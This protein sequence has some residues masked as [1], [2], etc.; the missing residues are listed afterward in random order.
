MIVTPPAQDHPTIYP[1]QTFHFSYP[2]PTTSI[3]EEMYS[4]HGGLYGMDDYRLL[5]KESVDSPDKSWAR[6]FREFLTFEQ[7]FMKVREGTP[8]EG[9]AWFLVALIY[10]PD[11]PIS[12][13]ASALRAR[14]VKKVTAW[15]V[16]L[17]MFPEAVI[18]FLA[19]SRLGAIH[20]L[21][22]D[23]TAPAVIA[24]RLLGCSSQVI[25]A[26]DYTKRG[27]REL[28]MKRLL[29]EALRSCPA[30]HTVL[31]RDVRWDD[32]V[33]PAAELVQ[34]E[35]MDSEDPLFIMYPSGSTGKPK[36]LVRS[37]AGFLTG[38]AVT[39]K[40]VIDIRP[41]DIFC[42]GD[43]AWISGQLVNALYVPLLLGPSRYWDICEKY[44]VTQFYVAPTTVR[45]LKWLRDS[46][47]PHT[48]CHRCWYY[49]AMGKGRAHLLDT[50]FQTETGSLVL[51]PLAGVTPTK[52]GSCTLPFFGV[53]T[54][55]CPE[56]IL[57]IR[58]PWPGMARSAWGD[59]QRFVN[60]YFQAFAGDGACRDEDGYYWLKGRID[61]VVNVDAYRFS[62]AEIKAA[63]LENRYT[64]EAAAVGI[65]YEETGQAVV[66]F[67]S[68]KQQLEGRVL[69]LG[70]RSEVS[71]PISDYA[72]PKAMYLVDITE[73]CSGKL[74]RRI[75]QR[76]LVGER[77]DFGD[78]STVVNPEAIYI[79]IKTVHG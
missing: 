19:I 73:A 77:A 15:A 49:H 31:D 6:Q 32:V 44:N 7:V 21:I 43:I 17:P 67:A 10:E 53:I 45:L 66:A 71:R 26:V 61:D 41:S 39:G 3:V 16:Y 18:I 74:T 75:L 14:G 30:V 69:R 50:Y 56:G 76:I 52:P 78:T 1:S 34:P 57:A 13:T 54:S 51:T 2:T 68:P 25:V 22:F 47:I 28:P 38:A 72:L 35:S 55:H 70:L 23:G 46:E 20:T 4:D 65:I 58:N 5:Y 29:D 40:C 12:S 24:D 27:G 9:V 64:A 59:H 48:H 11:E 37:T 42:A 60:T 36:G 63:F 8:S 79:V 62:I 33:D